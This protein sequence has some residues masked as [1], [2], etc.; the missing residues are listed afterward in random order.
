MKEL[1]L[2][3]GKLYWEMFQDERLLGLS[4][5]GLILYAKMLDKINLSKSRNYVDKNGEAFILFTQDEAQKTCRI[6]QRTFFTLKKQLRELGL[7]NYDEQKAKKAGVS[8]PIYVKHYS[9]WS[10]DYCEVQTVEEVETIEELFVEDKNNNTESESEPNNIIS[11]NDIIL[12]K[13]ESANSKSEPVEEN[14]DG[15]F[16]VF[17]IDMPSFETI[18]VDQVEFVEDDQRKS[19]EELGAELE[20][21]TEPPNSDGKSKFLDELSYSVI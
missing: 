21:F 5:D 14:L 19:L 1:N 8:T 15:A 11:N 10:N 17:N 9:D 16:G 20:R 12:E 13:P 18:E 2:N 4:N 3:F 6:K 7:I